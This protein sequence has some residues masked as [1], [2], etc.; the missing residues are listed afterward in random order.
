MGKGA[1]GCGND[2]Q[3]MSVTLQGGD[4]LPLLWNSE[5]LN[6]SYVDTPEAME[7]CLQALKDPQ[8]TRVGLDIETTGGLKPWHGTT[9]LIQIG[10]ELPEPRQFLID[11]WALDP[12]PVFP[13]L[14]DPQVE[15]V[16]HNGGYEQNHLYYRYGIV[17]TNQWD[18][19]YASRL[20]WKIK[21]EPSKDAQ[22]QAVSQAESPHRAK[23]RELNK[24][25]KDAPTLEE[26]N[27]IQRQIDREK[28]AMKRS[29]EEARARAPRPRT[30]KHTFKAVMRRY[31]NKQ[32]SK[33]QQTSAW[34]DPVLN[35]KQRRYAAMD[36]AGLLDVRRAM[37]KELDERGL[38]EEVQVVN[39]GILDRSL[40]EL[41][42]GDDGRKHYDR[43][44][45]AI[46][47]ASTPEQ[48]D[49]LI[50]LQGQVTLHYTFRQKIQELYQRRR[51]EV[52]V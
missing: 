37:G 32:I 24:K 2:A 31:L 23:L 48:L 51:G 30:V 42:G 12:S 20:A 43:L 29:R 18:T 46:A 40:E 16:T 35:D 11:C 19:C 8:V 9:R 41:A 17:L 10:V 13:V 45:R 26:R 52:G 33:E 21:G 3:G 25:L 14:E 50:A 6:I 39:R 5:E 47:N 4:D 49:E 27:K 15:V 7:E 38:S 44:A 1:D 22:R 36:V 28:L 34:D